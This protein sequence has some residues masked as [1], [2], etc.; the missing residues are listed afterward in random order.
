VIEVLSQTFQELVTS[1]A[2]SRPGEVSI[3]MLHRS[4]EDKRYADQSIYFL[5]LPR[6]RY[7][8]AIGKVG[9]DPAGAHF[10][11]REHRGLQSLSALGRSLPEESVPR[12][13]LYREVVGRNL[14]LQTAL[15]GEKVSSWIVPGMRKNA[16]CERFLS[17]AA[18]WCAALGR[19]TTG[20]AGGL[21][22]VWTEEF[23]VKMDRTGRSR[24]LLETAARAVW[25]G[26]DQRFPSVMAHGDF[27]GENVLEEGRRYGVIDWELCDE[28][29]VPSFD[30][31]D[32][33]LWMIFRTEGQ[34]VVDPF[35]AL[36][37][38]LTGI[39]PLAWELRGTLG[40]YAEEMG[41]GREL[42]PP[43]VTLAWAGYCL[44]KY[45]ALERDETGRFARARAGVR[46]ILDTD[47]EVLC[48][49]RAP[50]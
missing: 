35:A 6:E 13:L 3:M 41:F 29:S 24:E 47:P 10:L 26:F 40:R 1:G 5:F 33:C 42:L 23:S 9:F 31:L 30:I 38:L 11:E 19:A 46:K 48:G 49:D 16:R 37:R 8:R 12:P 17:W 7:P 21:V 15:R 2:P 27:C 25:D 4:H 20:D 36:D 39:D 14:S 43:L 45:R 44:K 28:M 34:G 50:R 32:L 22:P 18:S